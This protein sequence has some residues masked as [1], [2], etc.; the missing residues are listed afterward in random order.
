VIGWTTLNPALLALF[1]RLAVDGDS[2][3]IAEMA[4]RPRKAMGLDKGAAPADTKRT[5][6]MQVVSCV[7]L[8]EDEERY[9][10]SADPAFEGGLEV[11]TTGN[12]VL[13]LQLECL[14]LENTDQ[15][16]AWTSIERIRTRLARS[17][18][19]E[20]LHAVDASLHTVGNARPLGD[21][22]NGRGASRVMLEVALNVVVN[23]LDPVPGGWIRTVEITSHM[24]DVDGTELATAQQ[25]V[26]VE[27][28]RP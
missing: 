19:H 20:A 13:R 24:Q 17:S 14:A 10:D 1:A 9:G 4:D 27:V 6:T 28:S 25:M 23:D 15:S 21:R 2:T 12:R 5:L 11:L 26:A 8:G 7:G 3:Q 22:I 18:S 16:W